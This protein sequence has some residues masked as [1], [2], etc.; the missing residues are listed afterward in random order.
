M[1]SKR[2]RGPTMRKSILFLLLLFTTAVVAQPRQTLRIGIHTDIKSLNPQKALDSF[3]MGVIRNVFETLVTFDEAG[4]NVVGALATSWTNDA[5]MKTW[6]YTLRPNVRFHD[7]SPLTPDAVAKSFAAHPNFPHKVEALGADKVVFTLANADASFNMTLAQPYFGIL[8]PKMIQNA[9][10]VLGTGPFTYVSWDKGKRVTLRKNPAYWD[11]PAALDEVQFIVYPNQAAL[12][13]AVQAREIDLVEYLVGNIPRDLRSD[14]SL[15]LESIMG[16]SAGFL[17]FN[18]RRAP[19]TD[20]RMRRAAAAA[21]NPFELTQKFF[22]GSAGAPAT[23][24]MPPTF[25]SYFS[26]VAINRPEEAR[27]LVQEVRWN[28]AKPVVLLEAWAP[29]PYLPDPNGI[30][31]EVQKQLEAVGLKVTVERDPDRYFDRLAK[32]DF[33]LILNGW[34]ADS[35]DPV[36]FM[37]AI[38]GTRAIGQNNASQWSNAKFDALL[39]ACRTLSG[40]DLAA[41]L[42]DALALVD[43]EVPMIALFFGPQTVVRSKTVQGYHVHPFSRYSLYTV[44][45]SAH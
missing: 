14:P 39:D 22:S 33:D 30:A 7:G 5:S 28:F 35:P 45:L 19:F 42:K 32:G 3:S 23:A 36:D 40:K 17:S 15:A 2:N 9:T 43:E 24:L 41:R 21:V 10:L 11:K 38:L 27:R 31:L 29:R 25:F 18:T 26:K 34:I 4:T 1:E 44:S 20:V 13:K 8:S 12:L 16:N 37:S 6:T